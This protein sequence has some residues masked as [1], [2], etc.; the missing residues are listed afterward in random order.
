VVLDP[1]H[2]H[3]ALLQKTMYPGVDATVHVYAEDGADL[4]DYL[5]KI[6]GYNA[7]RDSPT[8]WRTLVHSA[9]DFLEGFSTERA[10]DVGVIAGNNRRKAEYITRAVEAG[11]HVLADKPMA[12]DAAGFES[13]RNAF[14][15]AAKRG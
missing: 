13:L 3:A 10:G 1:G 6:D 15:P 8:A 11:M 7:R 4:A 9:P 5:Q 2:F 14:A 12:I